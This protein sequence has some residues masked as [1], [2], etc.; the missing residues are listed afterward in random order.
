DEADRMLDMGFIPDIE[1]IC[2]L[3]PPRRQTLFFSATMPPEIRRLTAKFLRDPVQIEVARQATPAGTIN[4]RLLATGSKPEEKR[5]TL[6]DLIRGSEGFKNAIIFCNRKRDVSTLARS[7]QRHGFD[8]AELHGDM[9][10]ANRT[11]TLDRFR[12][13]E[14]ILLV[15]SDVAA[16]GLDIPAVSHIFNFDVPTHAEDYVHRIGR[17]GRAGLQ[18]SSVTLVAPG[19]RKYVDA[20][21]KLIGSDI[22]WIGSPTVARRTRSDE[23]ESDRPRRER[24]GRSKS[25]NSG[26]GLRRRAETSPAPRA[27]RQDSRPAPTPRV[28]PQ[29][30]PPAPAAMA[31][32]RLAALV[33][34]QV[35]APRPDRT[36]RRAEKSREPSQPFGKSDQVPAFLRR[37]VRA[38]T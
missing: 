36:P 11:A 12:Q 35:A 5:A 2:A 29:A 26:R 23:A 18:G 28:E 9:D 37:P 32:V 10:Q 38:A 34:P 8:A 17:T 13:D 15:A 30:S 21:V 27:E 22:E 14:L 19:D 16:R 4:Q 3:L 24:H 1:R 25:G 33:Q 20:I 31:E 7:L 6:R